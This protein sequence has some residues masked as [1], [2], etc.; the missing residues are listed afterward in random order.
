MINDATDLSG[1]FEYAW[2][3]AIISDK[4]YNDIVKECDFRGDNQTR[5]CGNHIRGF[6]EA[7]SAIDIYNIYAPIC[8]TSLSRTSPKLVVAPRLI[9]Q[10]V[11]PSF[12]LSSS[13]IYKRVRQNMYKQIA[14]YFLMLWSH[15]SQ[16]ISPQSFNY[17]M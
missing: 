7:Y 1:M 6:L 4:L 16:L 2:S 15:E 3:H 11:S 9:T 5:N 17:Y 8:L 10:H 13:A 12:F 14:F